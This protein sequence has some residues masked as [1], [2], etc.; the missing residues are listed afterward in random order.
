MAT[1]LTTRGEQRQDKAELMSRT[2]C[3]PD[4]ELMVEALQQ[5]FQMMAHGVYERHRHRL[6]QL[7]PEQESTI[8][9]LLQST[10][11]KISYPVVQR[12]K[13]S[14]GTGKAE[15]IQA[16]RDIFGLEDCSNP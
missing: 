14:Y 6:G 16:W 5:K 4:I 3:N 1:P 10:A 11:N 13:R 9:A 7:T 15:N 8:E 12:M 2:L